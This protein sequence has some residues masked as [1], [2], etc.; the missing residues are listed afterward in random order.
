M[1]GI[2]FWRKAC[3]RDEC[4]NRVLRNSDFTVFRTLYHCDS[5]FDAIASPRE[6]LELFEGDVTGAYDLHKLPTQKTSQISS[7]RFYSI[8]SSIISNNTSVE[9]FYF[10]DC[11]RKLHVLSSL[12]T[13]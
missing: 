3:F 2:E 13:S 9:S 11:L 7:I 5:L 4:L 8:P 6:L 1:H 12:I 10:L